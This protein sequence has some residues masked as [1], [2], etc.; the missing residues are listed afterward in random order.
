MKSEMNIA[1]LLAAGNGERFGGYKQFER[2]GGRMVYTYPLSVLQE[3]GIFQRVVLVLPSEKHFGLVEESV[4]KIVGGN[5]RQESSRIATEYLQK[6]GVVEE[7]LVL[8][9]DAVRPFLTREGIFRVLDAAEKNGAATVG[10]Y[11]TDTV[12]FAG[13]TI[14]LLNREKVFLA[15]TPQVFRFG[16]LKKGHEAAVSDGYRTTDD[17]SLVLRMGVKPQLVVSDWFNLKITTRRDLELFKLLLKSGIRSKL[18]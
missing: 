13:E 17:I 18:Q 15:E 9:H 14:T 5:T 4:E 2:I 12:Y 6:T 16:L 8:I 11:S 10:R 7:D 3:T 1:V